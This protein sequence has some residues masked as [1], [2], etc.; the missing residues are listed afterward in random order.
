MH[1]VA[2]KGQTTPEDKI[3]MSKETY[4]HFGQFI[5]VSKQPLCSLILYNLF[6]DFIH[7]YSPRAEADTPLGAKF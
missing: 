5:Q 2:G 4:C 7:V 1:I 6:Y 3:L